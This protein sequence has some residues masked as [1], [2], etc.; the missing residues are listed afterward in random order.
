M[1]GVRKKPTMENLHVSMENHN[2]SFSL[3][4]TGSFSQDDFTVG[5]N[6][7]TKSPLSHGEISSL[8]LDQLQQGPVIGRGNSSRVYQ[9][10]H[11]PSGKR[12]AVKVLQ[13]EL[14]GS[15][16]SRH[17]LLNEIKVVYKAASAHL[18][19]F[20][21]AFF[22]DG[23]IYIALEYMD[24]GSLE[25]LIK[26]AAVNAVGGRVPEGVSASI[27]FQIIQG[28]TYLHREL[29]AV[30]RDLKPA[31]VLLDSA[32]FVKLSDFGISKELGSGTYAQ[33][34]TQVG[35][36]AYMSPERVRGENYGFASDVWSLGLIALEAAL[37]AY[38]Y[39]GARNYFDLVQ[40]IVN[41]PIPTE[42]PEVQQLYHEQLSQMPSDLMQ[43]VHDSLSKAP[44]MRPD[45]IT[46]TRY[47][48]LA[49]HAQAPVDLRAY[50]V[51]VQ[52]AVMQQQQPMSASAGGSASGFGQTPSFLEH[53]SPS[54]LSGSSE[55]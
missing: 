1:P 38:P 14:E 23:S 41:G 53:A 11:T 18:V 29:R 17:M 13:A 43:L 37:G 19:T 51:S 28:L 35:T 7:I 10:I 33:A 40:T 6:G 26:A 36:L 55:I 4:D 47:P 46:L 9:A 21:D 39:P 52:P 2:K 16:E 20:Y 49:R 25:G 12:L 30:H 54:P 34:G 8:R 42:N 45:V 44:Q 3:S 27:L 22:H 24:C 32:G 48:F 31:N 5:P 15:R 50:L